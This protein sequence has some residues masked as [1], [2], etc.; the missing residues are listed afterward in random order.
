MPLRSYVRGRYLLGEGLTFYQFLF[1]HSS[2]VLNLWD[3]SL[4][5]VTTKNKFKA[6]LQSL[7]SSLYK[8]PK[9]H[10]WQAVLNESCLG[11]FSVVT[12][13]H[14]SGL[15]LSSTSSGCR[16]RASSVCHC[17]ICFKSNMQSIWS[18][19]T[20]LF[21]PKSTSESDFCGG[22]DFD[23]SSCA[24]WILYLKKIYK[25][26]GWWFKPNSNSL[27]NISNSWMVFS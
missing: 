17:Q 7:Q 9:S 8:W 20:P 12:D 3:K 2:H 25:W 6:I 21:P 4:Q 5:L 27:F 23:S 11:W 24:L 13:F 10:N 26:V 16:G 1:N 15:R 14:A 22:K 19:V 18:H